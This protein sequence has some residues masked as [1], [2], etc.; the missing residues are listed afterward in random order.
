MNKKDLLHAFYLLYKDCNV[1]RLQQRRG[2]YE[3]R[4]ARLIL[5][6]E[7]LDYQ[8]ISDKKAR[9][10]CGIALSLPPSL[11]PVY[12]QTFNHESY[13]LTHSLTHL[14]TEEPMQSETNN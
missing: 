3:S 10:T 6:K 8:Q 12:C 2:K 5:L 9:G 13:S 1:S 11:S 14:S 7:I 4:F